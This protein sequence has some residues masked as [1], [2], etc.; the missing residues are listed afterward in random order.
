MKI[1]FKL[2]EKFITKD[3]NVCFTGIFVDLELLKNLDLSNEDVFLLYTLDCFSLPR[4]K[5]KEYVQLIIETPVNVSELIEKI[6]QNTEGELELAIEHLFQD[7]PRIKQVVIRT[8][9]GQTASS[10]HK[11]IL[12]KKLEIGFEPT[13]FAEKTTA[14]SH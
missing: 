13:T 14:H 3:D 10:I 9:A 11:I 2:F 6:S 12:A 8:P 5:G 7:D 4:T 1:V